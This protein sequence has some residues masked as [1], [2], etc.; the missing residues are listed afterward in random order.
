MNLYRSQDDFDLLVGY[1]MY[2]STTAVGSYT[3]IN[4]TII[5]SQTK[6][7]RDASVTPGLTYYY[8]F[9]VVKTDTT[10]SAYSNIAT[11]TPLDTVPPVI[12]H[13]PVTSI[14]PDFP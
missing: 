13:T 5:P 4:S 9:T 10:E 8:K 12:T 3:W 1:H 14:P 2:R 7:Y 6:T 11:G